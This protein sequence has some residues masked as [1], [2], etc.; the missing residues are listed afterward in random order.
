M[1]LASHFG[2]NPFHFSPILWSVLLGIAIGL[3]LALVAIYYSDRVDQRE[4]GGLLEPVDASASPD[5][6]TKPRVELFDQDADEFPEFGP[7][8]RATAS[9]LKRAELRRVIWGDDHPLYD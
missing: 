5:A 8:D 6:S 3:S 4:F 2:L 7:D 1:T 9:L